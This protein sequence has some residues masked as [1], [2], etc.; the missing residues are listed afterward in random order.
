MICKAFAFIALITTSFTAQAIK[1]SGKGITEDE[2]AKAI[3]PPRPVSVTQAINHIKKKH[4]EELE[5]EEELDLS[6][7]N[8]CTKGAGQIVSLALES[9]PKLKRLNLSANR[10]YDFKERDKYN[11]FEI[12]L[13]ELLSRPT[14]ELFDIQYNGVANLSWIKH[15]MAYP[16]LADLSKIIAKIKWRDSDTGIAIQIADSVNEKPAE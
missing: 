6:S 1:Y 2:I 8:I 4:G 16:K 9:M 5:K 7:N 11:D 12:N 3:K 15:M 13:V 10:I 14:F